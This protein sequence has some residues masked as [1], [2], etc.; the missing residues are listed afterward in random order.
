[1]DAIVAHRHGPPEV[2]VLE[3]VPDPGPVPARS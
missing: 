2:L 1:M 3:Q